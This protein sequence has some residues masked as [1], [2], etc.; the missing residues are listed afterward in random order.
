MTQVGD[1]RLE[2]ALWPHPPVRLVTSLSRVQRQAPGES[3]VTGPLVRGTS[4]DF[5]DIHPDIK[6]ADRLTSKCLFLMMI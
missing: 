2:R 5:N 4:L 3:S 6:E 1:S